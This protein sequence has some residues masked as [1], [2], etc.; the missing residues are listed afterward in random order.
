M[1]YHPKAKQAL[2]YLPFLSFIFGMGLCL[3][4]NVLVVQAQED[5]PSWKDWKKHN[6]SKEEKQRQD[7]LLQAWR[8]DY[9]SFLAHE[10]EWRKIILTPSKPAFTNNF[11]PHLFPLDKGTYRISSPFGGRNH[12]IYRRKTDHHGI[13]MARIGEASIHGKAIYATAKGKVEQADVAGGYGNYVL[14]NHGAK[15]KTAYAHLSKFAVK[16]GDIVEAGQIIGYVGSTGRSTGPHL[17]YEVIEA[18]VRM[19]P[20]LFFP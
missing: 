1:R 8:N 19:N 15:Y 5:F 20:E 6:M 14:I 11:C 7:S 12:P 17:H 16:A 9:Q 13:D 10:E 3:F 2:N 4:G 18:G